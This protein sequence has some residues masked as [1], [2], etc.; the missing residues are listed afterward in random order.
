MANL[1]VTVAVTTGTQY[2][3]GSTGLI[4]T[5]DGSQ[6]ASF[7]FPWVA[8]GT[9]RLE[10]SGS[11]NDSH[12]L[13]F[14]T[15]NSSI[16]ATM[17]AGIISSGVTY[18]LDGASNQAAY[19]NTTT[20]NAATT[21]YIEIAPTSET[22][23]YFACWVHGIGMGGIMDMTQDTW[24]ALS[25]SQG[26]WNVQNDSSVALTGVSA[27]S[28]VGTPEAFNVV[29]WGSDAWGIENWG[30]S[31][32]T[33]TPT[34][35]SATASV[36]SFPYAQATD[37]WGR[38]EYGNAGWGV[39]YSVALS[40]LGLT[41]GV[42]AAEVQTLQILTAPSALTSSLGSVITAIE[43]PITAPSALTS[44]VG[45]PTYVGTN[46]G[47][48]RDSWGSEPWGDTEEPVI[49]LSGLSLTAS[50]GTIAAFPEQGWGRDTWGSENWG[51]SAF[52]ISLTGLS[53]TASVGAVSPTELSV[54]L[55]GVYATTS[56]GTPGLSYG[57]D[58]LLTG[59][60]ATAS[61]G[62][63]GLEIGVPLTGVSATSSL[64]SLSFLWIDF[65]S[66]VSATT[67]VGSVTVANVELVDLTGV[68]ATSSLGSIILEIGV[69][70]TGVS[71]ITSVGA[72]SPT[73]M[74]VGATGQSATV[75]LGSAGTSPLYYKDVDITGNTSYTDIEHTA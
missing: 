20:F 39:T 49:N 71:A 48:G 57:V 25:W 62:S 1:T 47:W 50:L 75:S 70:L 34:G 72:A 13:I 28:S 29:G 15:S 14:S 41:S 46:A 3:T 51:E 22:D 18:Y 52:T 30:E 59:V 60:S 44:S 21:R 8:S 17:Q 66:G 31:G 63:I 12:P 37:G 27:T 5:F 4:Y 23:F 56:L 9:V 43:I 26:N 36:G 10:Q 7:T 33:I 35:L 45:A 61:V 73:Q 16:L 68:G 54:G 6:P 69:P 2:V 40:G 64:G 11:S 74:T 19:T 24:G 65:P 67:S 32:L 55:T 42:G 38:L 58:D 53:T